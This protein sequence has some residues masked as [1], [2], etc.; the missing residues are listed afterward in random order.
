MEI[1][2][3]DLLTVLH[4]MGF[5]ALFMLAFAGAVAELYR[6]SAP[7][8]AMV[9]SAPEQRLLW[10]YLLAMVVLAWAT[11]VSGT[12]M[13]YPWYP[14]VPP[15]GTTDLANYPK[16]LLNSSPMTSKWHSLGM[17]WKEHVAWIA[18]I[19]ATVA[20]GLVVYYGAYL[21]RNR[22]V[23]NIAIGF[24]V[25]AFATAAVAGIFGALI[26]KAAPVH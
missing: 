18:P 24:F 1:S 22:T 14:A 2:L 17:E 26:T 6:L 3:R 23:R 15:A 9:P 8:A 12:Y 19:L 20:A 11:V 13:V 7:A 21:A 5:G 16:F 10:W 4:G 25:A